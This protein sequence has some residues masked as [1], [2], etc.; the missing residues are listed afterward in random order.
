MF[1]TL[2][3]RAMWLQ[4]FSQFFHGH[5]NPSYSEKTMKIQKITFTVFSWCNI[6]KEV[7]FMVCEIAMKINFCSVSRHFNGGQYISQ[8]FHGV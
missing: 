3:I 2:T 5:E 8:Y 1:N 7:I 4:G 6:A